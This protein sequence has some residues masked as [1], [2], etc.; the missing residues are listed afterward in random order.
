MAGLLQ[1]TVGPFTTHSGNWDVQLGVG[2]S[3]FML[4]DSSKKQFAQQCCEKDVTDTQENL[5]VLPQSMTR[6]GGCMQGTPADRKGLRTNRSTSIQ[7]D[8]RDSSQQW[9]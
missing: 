9:V 4:S 8:L 1:A 2:A 3:G 5:K 7:S 6:G